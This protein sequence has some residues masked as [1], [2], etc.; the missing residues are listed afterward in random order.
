MTM[1]N[2]TI[3]AR[4]LRRPRPQFSAEVLEL[5]A[6]LES[7]VDQDS[8]EF[9]TGSKRLAAMLHL[10]AE[11]LCSAVDVNMKDLEP[12]WPSDHP[13]CDDFRRV[14]AIREQLLAALAAVNGHGYHYR[15]TADDRH[16]QPTN[17][18]P[19]DHRAPP[20]QL[21]QQY[22]TSSLEQGGA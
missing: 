3:I 12:C 15:P 1:T 18:P 9:K 13:A 2:R 21:C 11:W 4:P 6:K 16:E 10:G 17:H 22:S 19:Q 7:M 14:R 20:T 8:H 5:F